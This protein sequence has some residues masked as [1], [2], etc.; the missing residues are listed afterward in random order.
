VLVTARS[1]SNFKPSGDGAPL[2][3]AVLRV[4][5]FVHVPR[6]SADAPGD[7][8]GLTAALLTRASDALESTGSRS[9]DVIRARFYVSDLMQAGAVKAAHR[10]FF[11]D[12][13]PPAT[14]VHDPGTPFSVDLDAVVRD[15]R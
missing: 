7:P 11:G 14:V 3:A 15:A 12:Q 1:S 4:G 5:P 8:S 10:A 6:I 9:S 13:A 2:D